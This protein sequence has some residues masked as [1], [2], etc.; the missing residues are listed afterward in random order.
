MHDWEFLMKRVMMAR[1]GVD[2]PAEDVHAHI[3]GPAIVVD[4][5]GLY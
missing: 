2:L 3:S 4:A 1:I 5:I